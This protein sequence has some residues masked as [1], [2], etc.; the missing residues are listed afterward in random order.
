[1]RTKRLLSLVMALSMLFSL[2]APSIVW[3]AEE[4][5]HG[6]TLVESSGKSTERVRTH[7]VT[8]RVSPSKAKAKVYIYDHRDD[9]NYAD[10]QG[11]KYKSGLK[12]PA[13]DYHYIATAKGYL[14]AEGDFTV[15]D[16]NV[17]I[18]VTLQKEDQPV[19]T[20]GTQP[21]DEQSRWVLYEG[22]YLAQITEDPVQL[23]PDSARRSICMLLPVC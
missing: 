21:A 5:G 14:P 3:A 17:R 4:A 8:I 1:M 16:K 19:P 18:K 7:K 10:A 11:T 9:G 22:F 20:A 13:G 12:L 23:M 2:F 15:A 6:A